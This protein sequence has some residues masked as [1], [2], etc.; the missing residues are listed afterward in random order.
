MGKTTEK[1]E[2][3]PIVIWNKFR[4]IRDTEFANGFCKI[5]FERGFSRKGN[6][7]LN[8]LGYKNPAEI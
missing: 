8:D 4:I 5:L 7:T 1:A 2:V 3:F 6:L